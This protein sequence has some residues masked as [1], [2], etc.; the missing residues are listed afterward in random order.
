[1]F[2]E[3]SE[4]LNIITQQSPF[5]IGVVLVGV[6]MLFWDTVE[7][8]RNDAANLVNAVFGARVLQRRVAIWIAGVARRPSTRV[9]S[10]TSMPFSRLISQRSRSNAARSS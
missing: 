2:T 7:V 4:L 3:I 10:S 8:G 9:P 6:G 1:M 5:V